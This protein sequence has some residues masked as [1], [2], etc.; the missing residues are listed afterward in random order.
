MLR[1]FT[2]TWRPE[3]LADYG[4]EFW[5]R[6]PGGSW[7]RVS[8]VVSDPGRGSWRIVR[9]REGFPYEFDVTLYVWQNDVELCRRLNDLFAQLERTPDWG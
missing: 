2:R 4:D 9:V 1:A 6:T 5:A 8:R 3:R 7:L